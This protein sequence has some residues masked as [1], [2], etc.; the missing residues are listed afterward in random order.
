M[1][2]YIN[3]SQKSICLKKYFYKVLIYYK[4]ICIIKNISYILETMSLS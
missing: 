2:I 3:L 4:F 1:F